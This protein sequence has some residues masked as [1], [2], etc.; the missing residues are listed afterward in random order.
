MNRLINLLIIVS[1]TLPFMSCEDN[2]GTAES[3]ELENY[4][5]AVRKPGTDSY[6]LKFLK[7]GEWTVYMG[8]S[9]DAIDMN[10]SVAVTSNDSI[11]I[12]GLN[13]DQRYYFAA[14]CNGDKDDVVIVSEKQIA[15]SGQPNFADL[16]G[17]VTADGHS[18]KWGKV[19]RSGELSKLTDN[20]IAYM[21][22]LKLDAIIDFRFPA[23]KE[24]APDRFPEGVDTIPIHIAD[25]SYDENTIKKWLM[26]GNTEAFDTML[27]HVNKVLVMEEQESFKEFFDH[28]EKGET[29]LFH[30]TK[31]K[32][33]AGF[34]AA[35]FLS[36]LG[37]DR[38]TVIDNYLES[39]EY[40]SDATEQTIQYVNKMSN[41][42]I[43]GEL[44]RPILEVRPEYIQTAFDI[45]D[46]EYGGVETYLRNNLQVDIEKLRDLYL[47]QQ[48]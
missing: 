25:G 35:M 45:I 29:I 16:G 26:T 1:M 18:V 44:L 27:I 15:V 4:V 41:G 43:N 46:K 39:N 31:G 24:K 48:P 8:T 37:V 11:V 6:T 20:D 38:E 5:S 22:S 40:L 13:V 19:Y 12:D 14:E 9:P 7:N 30:C 36:A 33:R 3:G 23:E 47:D 17:I 32:D 42:I 10:T 34:A 21:A 2:N 28:L